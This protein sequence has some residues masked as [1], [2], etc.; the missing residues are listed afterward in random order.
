TAGR[1]FPLEMIHLAGA[2]DAGEQL[3]LVRTGPITAEQVVAVDPDG[4]VLLDMNGS[5]DAVFEELLT[6]D[7]VAH[8][9]AVADD[10]V[11]LMDGRDMQALGFRATVDGLDELHQWL[12]EEVAPGVH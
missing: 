1:A 2:K 12:V 9:D 4:I 10:R 5:G 7:A 6:N 8:L 11:I 3:D